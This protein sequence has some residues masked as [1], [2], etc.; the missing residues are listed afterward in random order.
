[1]SR[2]VN[3]GSHSFIGHLHVYPLMEQS[4]ALTGRNTTGPPCSFGRPTAHAP[5]RRRADRS[6]T[7]RPADPTAGSVAT[8]RSFAPGGRPARP[9]AALQTTTTDD[10]QQNNT[11]P[12]GGPVISH[13]AFTP[14][15][16]ASPHFGRVRYQELHLCVLA[17]LILHQTVDARNVLTLYISSRF[18]Y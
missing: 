4:V 1:M 13:H 3:E 17:S 8:P 10:S 14:S 2:R 12:L 5:G 9:P 15:R 18:T 7:R 11:G 16:S 6:R